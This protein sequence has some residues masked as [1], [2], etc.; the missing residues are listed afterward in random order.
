MGHCPAVRAWKH[1][2]GQPGRCRPAPF[3]VTPRPPHKFGLLPSSSH[4][5]PGSPARLRPVRGVLEPHER[6]D[7]WFFEWLPVSQ[8]YR[9]NGYKNL[10]VYA[11]QK[12]IAAMKLKPREPKAGDDASP[13]PSAEQAQPGA[14]STP[15]VQGGAEKS[16]GVDEAGGGSG[17]RQLN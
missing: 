2:S 8:F 13:Q 9:F 5:F 6:F 15:D 12:Q 1:A 14:P 7:T 10:A 3:A 4:R 16:E 11:Q 17:S